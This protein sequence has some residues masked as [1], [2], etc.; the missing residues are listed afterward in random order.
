MGSVRLQ[1]VSFSHSHR[2]LL[3]EV[4]AELGPGWTG[5]VGANGAGKSTLLE[6]LAGIR[7]PTSGQVLL[8]PRGALV[9]LC[10]QTAERYPADVAAFARAASGPARAWQGRLGL[11]ASGL[12]RWATL[13]P[14]ERK[15]WQVA[16]ALVQ[17]PEVLLLDEPTNHLDAAATALL[18]EALRAFDGVGVLV[19]HQREVLDALCGSTFRVEAGRWR[20][21]PG[22]YSAARLDWEREEG[23][24]RD[25]RAHTAR[26]LEATQRRLDAQRRQ[27]ESATRGRSAGQRMRSKYDSDSRAL[28]ANFRA[29]M[30]QK[31]HA[32]A[33]RRTQQATAQLATRLEA[34]EVR[35]LD[36]RRLFLHFE[37][38]PRPV[39]ARLAGPLEVG[40]R[41]LAPQLSAQVGREA[42]VVLQGPNG[43]GKSTLLA[44]LVEAS[45]LPE[46]RWLWLP[47]ELCE[48]DVEADLE[49]LR[50]QPREVRGRTLQLVEAL[51]VAPEALLRTERPSAGEARKLRLALG[52]ARQVWL[53]V[54]DEPTNHLDLPSVERLQT[55][56]QAFPGALVVVTHDGALAEALGTERWHL[57][58]GQLRT[59][60]G[61]SW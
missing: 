5:V 28:G 22:P 16:A 15:R 60:A 4:T 57:E 41:V 29:E 21:W 35:H 43:A 38:C 45:A 8:S 7:A 58:G 36:E 59:A 3:E 50:E 34:Q 31:A 51:G 1:R 12:E 14:G 47:Q 40:G 23:A 49:A 25:A 24:A 17:E 61:P 55:A 32:G 46:D 33:L 27:L 9:A 30:A 44:R 42:H 11:E 19:A 53:A 48:A 13:S 20:L 56:L 26:A 39:V 10:A 6:L 52:L 18:V 54:L 2:P 37:R